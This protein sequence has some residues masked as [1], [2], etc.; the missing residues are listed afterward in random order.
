MIT[1][2]HTP[3]IVLIMEQTSSTYGL[4]IRDKVPKCY[5]SA[6]KITQWEKQMKAQTHSILPFEV[7]NNVLMNKTSLDATCLNIS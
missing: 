1:N 3:H 2:V 5:Q 7:R 4:T 6:K